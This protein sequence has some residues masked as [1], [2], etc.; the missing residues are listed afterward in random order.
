MRYRSAR[1]ANNLTARLHTSK[2]R[3]NKWLRLLFSSEKV[4]K[5]RRKIATEK[6]VNHKNEVNLVTKNHINLQ[7]MIFMYVT[8]SNDWNMIG[9]KLAVLPLNTVQT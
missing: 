8:F 7:N 6:C 3:E 4:R 5:S 2:K 9:R 1:G